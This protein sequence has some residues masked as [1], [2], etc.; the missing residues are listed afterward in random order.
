MKRL[1]YFALLLLLPGCSS[2]TNTSTDTVH[3]RKII[4][5]FAQ[6]FYVEKNIKQAFN[7]FVAP[8]YIQHNPNIADGR[9]AAIAALTPMFSNDGSSFEIKRIVVDGDIA[10]IHLHGKANETTLGGA[11]ADI[12]RIQDGKIVE[13]WDVIQTIQA[14]TINPHPYF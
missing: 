7:H 2:L 13:H 5:R 6:V 1:S 14:S 10:V 4:E 3:N 11:V 9:D 12:Y 8:D